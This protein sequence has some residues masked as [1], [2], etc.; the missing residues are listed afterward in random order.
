MYRILLLSDTHGNI[1]IINDLAMGKK[2][3]FVIHA[4]DFGFYDEAS[5]KRIS[6]RELLL[7]ITHSPC[8]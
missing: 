7:L 5:I 2:V 3:D 4:G 8:S 1:D 6:P